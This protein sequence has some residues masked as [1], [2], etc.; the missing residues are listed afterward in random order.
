MGFPSRPQD[1]LEPLASPALH[2]DLAPPGHLDSAPPDSLEPD[3]PG[4]LEP[5]VVPASPLASLSCSLRLLLQWL[6]PWPAQG[7]APAFLWEEPTGRKSMLTVQP[8][9]TL[10]TRSPTTR[11]RTIL[12]VRSPGTVTL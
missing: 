3:L 12:P 6:R 1:F 5:L 11:R 8:S 10:S 4:F 7:G 2:P 9:T